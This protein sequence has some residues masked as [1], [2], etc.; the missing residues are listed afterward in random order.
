MADERT[1]SHTVETGFVHEAVMYRDESEFDAA[2][3]DF[4]RAAAAADEPVLVALPAVRLNRVR[5]HMGGNVPEARFEDAE[6]V[7]RNPSCLLPM[8]QEWVH[9]HDGPVRVVSE[10][11]WP[12]RS[13]AETV[14]AL[15]S[16]ALLNYALA[17]SGA[18]VMSPFDAGHLDA[19]TLAGAE[20][21]H[22]TVVEGGRR[23]ASMAYRDPLTM[24]FGELW[25]L[26]S[27]PG[28]VSEHPLTGSVLELRHALADDPALGML[29]AQRRSDLVFA[30]GEAAS[31]AIKHSDGMCTARI[32][33]DGDEVVTEVSTHSTITDLMAG[34][35]RPAVDALEGRGLWLINQL[36]DLVELRSD[37]SGTTL[38]M[39]VRDN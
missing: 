13:R 17:G 25:P 16:E 21:T 35:R 4:M 31:N 8:I 30:V 14:E 10:V 20:M 27:P 34:C 9:S 26:Q 23:R 29:S 11:V 2:I 18:T 22:P 36:C 15:R 38:R 28:P 5:R 6:R 1:T 12:G 39:H 24:P 32:W 7:A 33:R 19:E 3:E 37:A